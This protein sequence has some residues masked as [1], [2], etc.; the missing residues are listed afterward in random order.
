MKKSPCEPQLPSEFQ[1]GGLQWS[2]KEVTD[3]QKN[4]NAYGLTHAETCEI[5]IDADIKNNDVRMITFYHEL[6]H[7][8]FQA[9]G[10]DDLSQNEQLVD[11]SAS[12]LWQMLK[13]SKWS[14]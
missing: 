4:A 13:T 8:L 11:T 1:L 10:R 12:L 6:F 7:A 3:L 14:Q 2:V 9:Q 5:M